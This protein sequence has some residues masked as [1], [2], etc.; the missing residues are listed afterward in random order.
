MNLTRMR[1]GCV[2]TLALVTCLAGLL[3][4]GAVASGH[5]AKSKGSKHPARVPFGFF[6]TV[7][8]DPVYPRLLSD[9]SPSAFSDQMNLMV[10]TGVESVRATFDWS[11]AQPYRTWSQVPSDQRAKFASDGVDSVP[12]DFTNLDA[13][14]A[15][16]ATRH[17]T[18]LPVVIYAPG[19][20]GQLYKGAAVK[21]P[22]HDAPY[23]DFV[24]ALV[25][26]YGPNGSYWR[27]FSPKLPITSWQVWNEP[28]VS[29]FWGQRP[30]APRY[31]ALLRAA[32][33]AIKRQ[34]PHARIVLAGL[35]NYSWKDLRAIY[36]VKGARSLFD[37]VALHP[38][39]KTPQGVLTIL[40]YGR[41]VMQ[42][43]G[44]GAKPMV[45]DEISWPSSKGKTTH[46][47]GYPFDTT[48]AG[49]ARAVS[50][51]LPLLAANR[52][53]LKLVGVYY[54]T[55]A[56]VETP[57]GLA[58]NYSG[59]LKYVHNAFVRK[60]VFYA[61]RHDALDLERCHQKGTVATRCLKP[62]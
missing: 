10:A 42:S 21:I 54:Y 19:W 6:G 52:A 56:G 62:F 55:W 46:N 32:R 44:D 7:L 61:Y 23:A 49:Q 11:A 50:Q 20:D 22:R 3:A 39:T 34:D 15:A 40:T 5:A 33:T 8:G 14:V 37:V 48:E 26:R 13:L 12:T 36:A 60:P 4:V 1:R 27:T 45:A 57:N 58:F 29:A 2:L 31:V 9:P 28:D 30:F 38:Y 51:V 17:M 43:Y 53:R 24:A 47:V 35:A 18:V 41:Q 16:A 59:L 25:K